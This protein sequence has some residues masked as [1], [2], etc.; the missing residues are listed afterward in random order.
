MITPKLFCVVYQIQISLLA[1]AFK[2]ELT[3]YPF[4]FKSGLSVLNTM[5]ET[6]K[7]FDS[8]FREI[9]RSTIDSAIDSDDI[10]EFKSLVPICM[11]KWSG[12]SLIDG[13]L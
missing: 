12:L 1:K 8:V 11:M 6:L 5:L 2:C 4:W 7:S 13:F 9:A 3:S 10:S